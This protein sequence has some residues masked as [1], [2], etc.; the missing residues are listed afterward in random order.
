MESAM[1]DEMYA[2]TLEKKK[3]YK[4]LAMQ[5]IFVKFCH[6]GETGIPESLL[7]EID[8]FI[9]HFGATAQDY[10]GNNLLHLAM[11]TLSD[12]RHIDGA[13]FDIYLR[14]A[15]DSHMIIQCNHYGKEPIRVLLDRWFHLSE[16][17]LYSERM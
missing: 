12:M 9:K 16:N 15:E 3:S 2:R 5:Q 8:L 7:E 17:L 4:D 14:L 13:L 6:V 11:Y 1:V 10:H